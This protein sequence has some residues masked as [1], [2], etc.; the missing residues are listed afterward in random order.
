MDQI[1]TAYMAFKPYRM[2]INRHIKATL[3]EGF[4]PLE[5]IEV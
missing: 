2:D 5:L 1:Q 4:I 3:A